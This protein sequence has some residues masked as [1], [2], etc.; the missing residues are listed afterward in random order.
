MYGMTGFLFLIAA[1]QFPLEGQVLLW[2]PQL[3]VC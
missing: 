2:H 3:Q 1:G